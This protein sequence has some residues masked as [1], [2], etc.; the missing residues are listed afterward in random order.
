[1][2]KYQ[3]KQGKGVLHI[4]GGRFF[5]PSISYELSDEVSQSH[6]CHFEPSKEEELNSVEPAVVVHEI[7]LPPPAIEPEGARPVILEA[8]RVEAESVPKSRRDSKKQVE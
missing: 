5:Y 8:V 1:M 3:L 7:V 6:G 2:I 4:G